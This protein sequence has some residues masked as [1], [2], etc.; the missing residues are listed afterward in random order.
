MVKIRLMRIGAK[1]RPFYRIVVV[2]ERDKRNGSYID[3]L[4]TYNPLT[5]P[6]E[7]KINKEKLEKWIKLGAQKSDGL[8]RIL[9]EAPQKHRKPKKEPVE[10]PKVAE[11]PKEP[12]TEPEVAPT[13][14]PVEETPV[15][16]TVEVPETTETVTEET[17]VTSEGNDKSEDSQ[18]TEPVAQVEQAPQDNE[19][20]EEPAKEAETA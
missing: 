3:L 4:G 9:K 15:T 14:T 16:E 5:E 12:V 13:E 20:K 11:T 19:T 2:D 18:E 10:A 8:L 17:P 6:K 1:K 7:I